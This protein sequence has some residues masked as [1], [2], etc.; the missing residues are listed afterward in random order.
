VHFNRERAFL[1]PRRA[2]RQEAAFAFVPFDLPMREA[3]APSW[4]FSFPLKRFFFAVGWHAAWAKKI[5][6]SPWN[7]LLLDRL[8]PCFP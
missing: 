5:S 7:C 4:Q 1:V 8:E 3:V 2:G 6:S